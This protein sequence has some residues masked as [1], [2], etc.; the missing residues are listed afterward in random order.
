MLSEATSIIFVIF[1]N[2][3]F[4]LGFRKDQLFK[5]SKLGDLGIKELNTLIVKSFCVC[6]CGCVNGTN[7]GNF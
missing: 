6:H 5:C 4:C 1:V 2:R 3:T 7:K